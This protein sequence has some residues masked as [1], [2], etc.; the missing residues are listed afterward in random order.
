VL[1]H[2][3]P[4]PD[5]AASF[6]G[7]ELQH[8]QTCPLANGIDDICDADRQYFLDHPGEWHYT[9]PISAAE[10]QTMLHI[11][12]AGA[13]TNPDHACPAPGL[14]SYP[15]LLQPR[16][17]RQPGAR[18]RRRGSVVIS[19]QADS[20]TIAGAHTLASVYRCVLL[21]IRQRRH[22][23]LPCID[24][25]QLAQALRRAHVMSLQRHEVDDAAQ[26]PPGWNDQQSSDDWCTTGEAAA[27]LGLSQRSVQRMAQAPGGLDAIRA[28]RTYLLPTAPLLVLAE[29]RARDRRRDGLPAQLAPARS[30]AT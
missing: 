5:C 3:Q 6:A 29:R 15:H 7:T 1:R 18:P 8:E 16:R 27:L 28:G 25:Q 10:Y 12:P 17:F 26:D 23:G 13:A 30:T 14:G 19:R 11:D 9:R 22:D 2:L 4:C 24:L 20:V 21:G